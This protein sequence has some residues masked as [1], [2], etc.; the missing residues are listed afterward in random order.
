MRLIFSAPREMNE[1]EKHYFNLIDTTNDNYGVSYETILRHMNELGYEDVDER[2]IRTWNEMWNEFKYLN[3]IPTYSIK[4]VKTKLSFTHKGIK[5]RF[6]QINSTSE[7][8]QSVLDKSRLDMIE[9][10]IK[11][12]NRLRVNGEIN[13]FNSMT[14]DELLDME[15]E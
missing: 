15:V 1:I 14:I 3:V 8:N 12:R 10:I 2:L 4:K 5:S 13:T 6:R 11:Y 7:H 9:Y